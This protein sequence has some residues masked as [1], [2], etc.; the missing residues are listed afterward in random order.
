M[1]A[2]YSIGTVVLLAIAATSL[3]ATCPPRLSEIAARVAELRGL[4]RSFHPPC[5]WIAA[6][7]V[8][9]ALD[10][11]LH[12]D[13]P[14]PPSLYL[15]TLVRLGL[16]DGRPTA[17]YPR[18]LD[19]YASQVLGFYEP[20][21]NEMVLVENSSV[22]S[23]AEA[24]VWAH[25][26]EHAV[27][28]KCFGLPHRLLAMR[29]NGDEQRAASA[30]AEGDA[31]LVM[32][33]LEGDTSGGSSALTRAEETLARQ[34]AATPVP[35][36]LPRYFVDD[37]V[38]PYTTGFSTVASAYRR[39]GWKAVDELLRSPPGSTAELLHP[40]RPLPGPALEDRDLLP[41]PEG[42]SS[43][44]TD[45]LGEWGLRFLLSR[46]TSK[47][48]ADRLAAAWDADRLRLIR[49]RDASDRWALAWRLRCRTAAGCRALEDA[50]R[51]Y[52]PTLLADLPG[53]GAT[54]RLTW[55]HESRAIELR[56]NWP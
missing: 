47:K 13:L 44:V 36:G 46:K 41:V 29:R 51:R 11:K 39:H 4:D 24:M 30:I 34:I 33:L 6:S 19:F 53:G 20:A 1:R 2:K 26:L 16:V 52:L 5:R 12:R 17:I 37:L 28:E 7:Q 22:P 15:E 27:Q 14:L 50:L 56:A 9:A 25:E 45:T 38:F 49:R 18:L 3:A 35:P 32:F 23:G 8:R 48:Q 10:G 54:L 40:G 31:M 55:R 43:V 21:S 42:W